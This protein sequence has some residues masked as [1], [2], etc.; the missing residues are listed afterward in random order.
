MEMWTPPTFSAGKVPQVTPGKSGDQNIEGDFPLDSIVIDQLPPGTR[1]HSCDRYGASAWTVTARITTTLADGEPKLYFLKCA[2]DAQ[3]RAMLEGESHSMCELY[4]T[5]PT[6][7]PKPY[8]WG[9]LNVSSPDTYYFLCD[10]IEMTSQNPDPVQLCTRL[11]EMHQASGSPTG[12]FGFHI[13][14]CQ[15]NLSQQTA[16]NPS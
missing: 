7:V 10:F 4:R 15:G 9:K 1:V 14:T 13:N 2:E 16:W 12:E 8:T 5:A 11:V 6:F 3:G